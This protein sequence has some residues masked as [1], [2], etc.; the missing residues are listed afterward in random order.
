[1]R[2][3]SLI[4]FVFAITLASGGFANHALEEGASDRTNAGEED[5]EKA[6]VRALGVVFKDPATGK[7]KTDKYNAYLKWQTDRTELVRQIIDADTDLKKRS[8]ARK[9]TS[10][11]QDFRLF[12]SE[13]LRAMDV[14]SAAEI[15]LYPDDAAFKKIKD[16]DE[17]TYDTWQKD[18]L[19]VVE[20]IKKESN[21]EKKRFLAG[22][23]NAI[24][25]G[26]KIQFMGFLLGL[27]AD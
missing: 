5:Q 3:T 13:I 26:F 21:D 14:L 11:D 16:H 10:L 4:A 24:D 22:K 17:E 9:L 7:Q 15:K 25:R 20:S 18:R 8:L 19:V 2:L 12:N 1:M 27:S 6:F 23:L